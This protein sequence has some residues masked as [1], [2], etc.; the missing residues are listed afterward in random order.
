M[1]TYFLIKMSERFMLGDIG[2]TLQGILAPFQMDMKKHMEILNINQHTPTIRFQRQ[3]GREK[4][5]NQVH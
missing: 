2:S 1:K 4:Q 3:I 5:S